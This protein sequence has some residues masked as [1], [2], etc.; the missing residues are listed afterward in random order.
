M[1]TITY[2]LESSTCGTLMTV[3]EEGFIGRSKAAYG[4]AEIW[5]K[6]M[7]WLDAYLLHE[8]SASQ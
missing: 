6:V 5:E 3:R 2:Y 7:T 8:S 1:T 4:N